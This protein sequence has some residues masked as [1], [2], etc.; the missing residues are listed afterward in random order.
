M[1]VDA[2][3]VDEELFQ[4]HVLPTW[5]KPIFEFLKDGTLPSDEILSRKIQRRA[6]AYTI[7]NAKLY[8][9]SVTCVL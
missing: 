2:M 5:E 1:S 6:N 4:V 3:E 9:R 8:K 7:I